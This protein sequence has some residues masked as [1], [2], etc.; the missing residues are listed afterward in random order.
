VLFTELVREEHLTKN[1][2]SDGWVRHAWVRGC[3]HGFVCLFDR[4]C[5]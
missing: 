2:E 3:V 4:S 1:D 5:S